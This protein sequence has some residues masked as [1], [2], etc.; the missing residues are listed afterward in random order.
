MVTVSKFGTFWIVYCPDCAR[1]YAPATWQEAEHLRSQ[2]V[3]AP[4]P[5]LRI[6]I[7]VRPRARSK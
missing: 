4:E 7:S 6:E 1:Q 2:H 5:P 3:C